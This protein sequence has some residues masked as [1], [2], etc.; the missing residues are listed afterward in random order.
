MMRLRLIFIV[1][2]VKKMKK[3]IV[4]QYKIILLLDKK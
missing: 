3:V 1:K 4:E 2:Y